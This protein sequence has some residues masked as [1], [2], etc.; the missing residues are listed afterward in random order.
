MADGLSA[1][2]VLAFA[3]MYP[4]ALPAGGLL[5]SVG[6]RRRSQPGWANGLSAV[7]WWWEVSRLLAA[8]KVR[9]GRLLLL[10]AARREFPANPIFAAAAED[11]GRPGP[12]V[13][14]VPPRLARFVG[15]EDQ[16]SELAGKLA[17]GSVVSVVALAGMGGVG[18]TALAVEYAW[19]H[20]EAFDVVWW[21]SAEQVDQVPEQLGAL[22][23]AL[24][25]AVGAE[26][27]AVVAELRR[28]GRR[29]LLV[30]DNAE[31]LAAVAP[32]RPADGRG[33]VLVT[34]RRA[35]WDGLGAT[36]EVPTLA[37]SESVALLAG[38]G[39][40]VDPQVAD[41][42]AGL[43]GDLALAV[44]QA[45]AF[46]AQTRT[47]LAEFAD[48][49]AVRLDDVIGLG[50]VAERAG[51]TVATLWDLSTERL[52]T[53][54]PAAVELLEL[55]ALCAPEPVPLDLFEGRAN[56]L[57]G[58]PLSVA[59]GDRVGWLEAVGALVGY[60]LAG[61]DASTVVVHRLVA[62]ATRR[63]TGQ[64]RQAQ[65][66]AVLLGLLR[67]DLPGEIKNTPENWPRWGMLLPHV[68]AVV[69]RVDDPAGTAASAGSEPAAAAGD[70]SWLCDRTATYLQ[71]HGQAGEALP[72]FQRALAIDEAVYGPDHPEVTA[73]L[74]NL[75]GALRDLGRAGEALPLVRRALAIDEA[76]YGPDHPEVASHLNNLA[77]ALRTLGRAGEALPLAQRALAIDEAVYGPDHPVIATALN[78][79]AVALRT[80]GRAGEALPLAQRALA[81]D[82]AVY[83]PDHPEV[84]AGLNNLA[85]A[86]R[87]LGQVGEALPLFRRALAIAEAVYGPDHPVIATA[88]NN[89]AVALQDL[90]RAAE[91]LPLAQRALAIAEAVY[92]PDHPE[93]AAGLNNLA[94]ALRTLGR[95]GQALPLAQRALAIAEAVYGPDHPVIATALNN[96]AAVLKDL[97]RAGEALPLFRRAL[98][99]DEAVYGPDH[100]EVAAGL[101]SLA[102]VLQDLGRGAEA[103]PLARRALAIDETVYGP[104]HPEVASRLNNL[105]GALRTLGRVGEALPLAQRALAVAEAVYGP[106]HPNCQMI[107]GNLAACDAA[108]TGGSEL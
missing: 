35:G 19:R 36:V 31:E 100:P 43:L 78:N 29:W 105:A 26:P 40:S 76:V 16:L 58:G 54:S 68:R 9:S 69:A 50:E 86:L 59:A 79:L 53:V 95:V 73:G 81:I 74:S 17:A 30:F 25:L 103:L 77:V 64:A 24:G 67:A 56:L 88:L 46:C 7:D 33:R 2:E 47:P 48:L 32:F 61:R 90:G 51:E 22:G 84:A 96:L 92:G 94:G 10:E 98:A 8:G 18:K 60:S 99:I 45:A 37:R 27:A 3:E 11:E 34:S 5:A 104:D 12:A 66:L 108:A 55:L 75:A 42:V 87:T 91:A 41:R 102:A 106:D 80:L 83:G 1:A 39:V 107:R 71:V 82:E 23:E 28:R 97:G 44:E 20:G 13:W 6:W 89:L 52:A 15:R 101:N 93:V 38:R 65:A 14:N 21:V 57:G 4:D 85:G 49:L 70:L 72:L 62:A 63:R